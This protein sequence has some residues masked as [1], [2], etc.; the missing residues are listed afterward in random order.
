MT[1]AELI[2]RLRESSGRYDLSEEDWT[3]LLNQACR[4]LDQRSTARGEP[5]LWWG[6]VEEG[7]DFVVV[8]NLRAVRDVW[9]VGVGGRARCDLSRETY[10]DFLSLDLSEDRTLSQIRKMLGLS[11]VPVFLTRTYCVPVTGRTA[12]R[13]VEVVVLS[14]RSL[15][16]VVWLN[17]TQPSVPAKLEIVLEDNLLAPQVESPPL[18]PG[19][20]T[21]T[22]TAPDNSGLV[23]DV[24]CSGAGVFQT[25]GQFK[26]VSSISA[27]GFQNLVQGDEMITVRCASL[28]GLRFALSN[29]TTQTVLLFSPPPQAGTVV[30]VYGS[31]WSE[32]LVE[33]GSENFWTISYPQVLMWAVM[34]LLEVQLRN[35]EG[36]LDWDLAIS[37]ALDQI[38]KEAI[39][40]RE[41]RSPNRIRG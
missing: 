11:P 23:E 18:S 4:L 32:P 20:I 34:Y 16:N 28:H 41:L 13:P 33:D 24:H 5:A 22:G 8:E 1:K 3:E 29:W 19:T 30:E 15:E 27:S 2:V 10:S 12:R 26:S 7:K 21:I 40:E 35:R 36:Q 9:L 37:Q 25:V 31:F 38:D 6:R 14:R 39:Y 17:P